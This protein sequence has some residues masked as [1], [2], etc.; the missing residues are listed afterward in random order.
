MGDYALIPQ[1]IKGLHPTIK[2]LCLSTMIYDTI[3]YT[4]EEEYLH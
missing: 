3:E 2:R 4:E 1:S